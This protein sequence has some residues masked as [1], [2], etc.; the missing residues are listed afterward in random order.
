MSLGEKVRLPFLLE[1]LTGMMVT[2]LEDVA[3]AT[4]AEAVTA[5]EV[6]VEVEVETAFPG[7]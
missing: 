6:E 1:T 7:P 5:L 3:L 2:L 4:A